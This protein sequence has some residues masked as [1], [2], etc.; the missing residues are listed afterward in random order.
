VVALDAATPSLI[1]AK[2]LTVSYTADGV[3]KTKFFDGLIEGGNTLTIIE[4]DLAGNQTTVNWHV[5]VDTLAPVVTLDPETPSMIASSS[6]TV[7]YTVDGVFKQKTFTNLT[8]GV[9]PLTLLET[10]LAGNPTAVNFSVNYILG[11]DLLKGPIATF[12]LNGGNADASWNAGILHVTSTNF[13]G[14]GAAAITN[15]LS[16]N[17]RQ[18]QISYS[19]LTAVPNAKIEYKVRDSAGKLI[20]VKTQYLNLKNTGGAVKTVNTDLILS[21]YSA[22]DEI[23]FITQGT[24]ATPLDMKFYGWVLF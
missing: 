19:S 21:G 13:K 24:G 10:D 17:G 2:T 8:V 12:S 4:K 9:N 5:T 15:D 6:F 3:A 23:V 16:I 20:V 7:N 22:V 14:V 18:L 11:T 1:K